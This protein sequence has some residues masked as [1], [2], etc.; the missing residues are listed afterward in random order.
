MADT[1]T[2]VDLCAGVYEAQQLKKIITKH[3]N[4]PELLILKM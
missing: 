2:A 3:V 4:N 1:L